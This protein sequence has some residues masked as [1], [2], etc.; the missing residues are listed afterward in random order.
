MRLVIDASVA[1]KLV[2]DENDRAAARDLVLAK[3][4]DLT[5]P[6]FLLVEAGN[7]L[8][9][10]ARLG[11]IT[12]PQVHSGISDLLVTFDHFVPTPELIAAATQLSLKL[13]HPV[14]DCIYLACA[15]HVE[16]HVVT[17][18]QRFLAAATRAGL[19][20]SFISFPSGQHAD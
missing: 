7:I 8:W 11:E 9:K 12:A 1:I 17:A 5:V 18:D 3:G 20:S 14:Y 6:D 10:K 4:N 16:G 19:T 2:V 15:H 13:D